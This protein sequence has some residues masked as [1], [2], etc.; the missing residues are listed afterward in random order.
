MIADLLELGERREHHPLALYAACR[1][2]FGHRLLDHGGIERGLL[3]AQSAKNLHLKLFGQVRN[4]RLVGLEA[5]QDERRCQFLQVRRRYLVARGLDWDE[6]I[7]LELGLSADQPRIKELH[8]RP[9]I[10]HVVLDRSAGERD[11]IAAFE[12]ARGSGQ[13]ALRILDVLRLVQNDS[14]PRVLGQRREIAVQQAVTADHEIARVSGL[15]ETGFLLGA[16]GTMM[17]QYRK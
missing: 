7:P 14:R 2:E 12:R 4:N 15:E 3:L 8:Q 11:A 17:D 9:Q 13:L 5:A 10:A 6:E 1:F 16:G